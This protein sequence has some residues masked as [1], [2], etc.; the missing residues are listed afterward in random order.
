M[1]LLGEH[2]PPQFVELVGIDVGPAKR[3]GRRPQLG[4]A[5]Q[6]LTP[7]VAELGP[8]LARQRPPMGLEVQ[9]AAPHR[10]RRPG[11]RLR[12]DELE[13]ARRRAQLDVRHRVEVGESGG[14]GQ[15]VACR[16]PAAV[17]VPVG[18]QRDIAPRV[19]G[20]ALHRPAQLGWRDLGAVGVDGRKVGQHAA[21]V[22]ALPPERLVRETVGLVPR[23]LLRHEP[24]HPSG[25]EDLRQASRIAEHVGD[26][27]LG[28]RDPEVLGEPPLTVDDLAGDALPR[29]QVHVR[30]DPHP[31]D[32]YPLPGG[33]LGDDPVEQLGLPLAHPVVLLG[34]RAREHEVRRVVHQ[35]D[36][37]GERPHALAHRLPDR[38]QPRRVDVGVS[39]GDGS[40]GGR[41][42]RLG[43]RRS[44]NGAHLGGRGSSGEGV[45][46]AG[47]HVE[48]LGA[49]PVGGGQRAHHAVEDVVVVEQRLG[50][51]VDDDEIGA[52]ELVQR[53]LA[54]S[55][56]RTERGRP[57]LRERRVRRRLDDDLHRSWVG[58]DR[59]SSAPRVDPLQR[60]AVRSA[61][62][63]L[64][65]ETRAVGCEP[66]I[67]DRLDPPSCPPG[68]HVG[69]AA[70][71]RR[72]PRWTPRRRHGQGSQ[73]VERRSGLDVHRQLVG[74]DEGQDP[75][76]QLAVD[77]VLDQSTVVVHR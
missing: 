76:E 45:E 12:L 72:P 20:E 55:R 58:D 54:C 52:G 37:R 41:R 13:E 73:R 27:H 21:A 25:G 36:C 44:E 10:Y 40:V 63:A 26:P 18:D 4:L 5:Q 1:E 34:L 24:A 75:L 53:R 23:Q 69:P 2:F 62:E 43:Q 47:Q 66:E 70:E 6:P 39:C 11:R 22:D 8:Q 59:D 71:P 61:H 35:A 51:F 3:R 16:A 19:L 57:E 38:P 29:R 67:D 32:R 77:P 56:R 33:D 28:R 60:F 64:A 31:S 48:Q 30:F 15:H 9:L 46:A 49:T 14:A 42:R 17:A 7:A 50:L 65:L 74:V 68:G